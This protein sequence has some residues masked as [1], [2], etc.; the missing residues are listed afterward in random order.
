M[1]T[2]LSTTVPLVVIIFRSAL[3]PAPFRGH[4]RGGRKHQGGSGIVT[5]PLVNS[6]VG[7][8]TRGGGLPSRT[9]RPRLLT[10]LLLL[11]LLWLTLGLDGLEVGDNLR[12]NFVVPLVE[13]PT[14]LLDGG[15]LGLAGEVAEP[16][17][18][19]IAREWAILVR[20]ASHLPA[21]SLSD[22]ALADSIR[23]ARAIMSAE[24]EAPPPAALARSAAAATTASLPFFSFNH[25]LSRHGCK[26]ESR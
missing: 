15:L 9:L 21:S 3:A 24:R 6:R 20:L 2:T 8:T 11:L 1:S 5:R 17:H 4:T 23:A 22:M 19:A 25:T 13:Q 7:P 26:R 14:D 12:D 18:L 16:R 10:L